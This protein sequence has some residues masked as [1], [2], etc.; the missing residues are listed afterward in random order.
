C[1]FP[2]AAILYHSVNFLLER[3]RAGSTARAGEDDEQLRRVAAIDEIVR[4]LLRGTILV[5]VVLA[6]FAATGSSFEIVRT[7]LDRPLPLLH[8]AEGQTP[9]TW[10]NVALAITFAIVFLSCAR[11]LKLALETLVLPLTRLE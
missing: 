6:L 2:L 8:A 9:V 7:F 1:A 3:W 11:R 5:L 4:F 10:W